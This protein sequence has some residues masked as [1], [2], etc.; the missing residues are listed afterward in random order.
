MEVYLH[1][2]VP[3]G[4]RSAATSIGSLSNSMRMYNAIPKR[5]EKKRKETVG[6]IFADAG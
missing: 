6:H 5:K 4:D 1:V 3:E 2:V